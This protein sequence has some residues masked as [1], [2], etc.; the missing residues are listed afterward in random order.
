M[1][2][3]DLARFAPPTASLR[4]NRRPNL[5]PSSM[6]AGSRRRPWLRQ[7]CPG[8]RQPLAH[9][10]FGSDREAKPMADPVVE[11]AAET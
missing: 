5:S 7:P 3:E 10:T 1:T 8:L 2:M 4:A 11:V 9:G 6:P